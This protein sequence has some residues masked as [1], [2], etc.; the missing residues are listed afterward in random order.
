MDTFLRISQL[1]ENRQTLTNP[2]MIP[3]LLDKKQPS[4]LELIRGERKSFD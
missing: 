1:E 4:L 3:I 2:L